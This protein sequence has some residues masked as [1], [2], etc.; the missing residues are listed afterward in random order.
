MNT[1]TCF[2]NHIEEV[3]YAQCILPTEEDKDK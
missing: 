3:V 2:A 1:S